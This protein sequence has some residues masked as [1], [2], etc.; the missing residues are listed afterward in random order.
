MLIQERTPGKLKRSRA[1]RQVPRRRPIYAACLR[2]ESLEARSLLSASGTDGLAGS[3]SLAEPNPTADQALVLG[4]LSIDPQAQVDGTIGNGPA[5]AAD[6]DWYSFTLDGP[7]AVHVVQRFHLRIDVGE[8][9]QIGR[10][11]VGVALQGGAGEDLRP[12]CGLPPAAFCLGVSP[13]KAA[14][15]GGPAKLDVS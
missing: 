2:V 14:N 12:S 10:H 8:P 9:Q 15:S 11:V 6:V 4:D 7:A 1:R 13:R 5:G 3:Q